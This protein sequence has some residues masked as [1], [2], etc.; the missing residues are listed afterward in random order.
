MRN[1]P[2][3]FTITCKACG[4]SFN[5]TDQQ[6]YYV[7]FCSCPKC[8]QEMNRRTMFDLKRAYFDAVSM[9]G[10]V[11]SLGPFAPEEPN[12][13]FRIAGDPSEQEDIRLMRYIQTVF[14]GIAEKAQD[15]IKK[16]GENNA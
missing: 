6:L 9:M 11:L 12:F 2:D 13:T 16:E 1:E 4:H 14:D 3:F 15:K 5:L 7:R 8:G 10:D